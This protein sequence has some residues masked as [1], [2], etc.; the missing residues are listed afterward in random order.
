MWGNYSA[1][2]QDLPGAQ[3]V[4]EQALAL[5]QS[6]GDAHGAGP[7]TEC[8]GWIEKELGNREAAAAAGI[9][10]VRSGLSAQAL[11]PALDASLELAH[12]LAE[13]ATTGSREAMQAV[14]L[15]E[16][17]LLKSLPRRIFAGKPSHCWT[18]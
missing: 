2:A 16:A 11:S 13:D 15:A 12:L 9:E 7:Y 14:Q 10:A 8:P 6:L 5:K 3:Q 17:I 18:N 1:E 4:L